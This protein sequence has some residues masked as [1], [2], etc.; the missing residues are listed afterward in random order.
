[1]TAEDLEPYLRRRVT[2]TMA[3]GDVQSGYLD[4]ATKAVL[5]ACWGTG[6]GRNGVPVYVLIASRQHP[7][8]DPERIIFDDPDVVEAARIEG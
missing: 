6:L 7:E 1:M 8:V 3:N 4:V 2:L 5:D